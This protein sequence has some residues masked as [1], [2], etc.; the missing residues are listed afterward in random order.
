MRIEPIGRQSGYGWV[1]VV[2]R[3]RAGTD[4]GGAAYRDA[5]PA[6]AHHAPH[7]PDGRPA[8]PLTSINMPLPWLAELQHPGGR[9]SPLVVKDRL[10][11]YARCVDQYQELDHIIELMLSEA[12]DSTHADGGTIY[13][14][15][16]DGRLRF[17]YFQN[18]SMSAVHGAQEHAYVGSEIPID[19]SS[20]CGYVAHT[21]RALNIPDAYAIDEAMPYSFN[22]SFDEASGYRTLSMLTTPITDGGEVLAVLQLIN[23]VDG[24]GAAVAFGSDD[25]DY[26]QMLAQ[27]S[28]PYLRDALK[29]ERL[30]EV[31]KTGRGPYAPSYDA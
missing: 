29:R 31:R 12:R 9:P 23:S 15:T 19:D 16:G 14:V 5:H 24:D 11:A 28:L 30:T 20:I 10:N 2:R 7:V 6:P 25:E 26:A 21:G 13:L 27:K 22:S 1:P 18:D 8:P 4:T 3:D 17:S